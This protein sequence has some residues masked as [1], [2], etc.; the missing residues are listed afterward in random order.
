MMINFFSCSIS[1]ATYSRN[2]ENGGF[3]TIISI[4]SG[5]LIQCNDE[6]RNPFNDCESGFKGFTFTWR[7][8]HRWNVFSGTGKAPPKRRSKGFIMQDG[9]ADLIF[10][11][12][13]E[14]LFPSATF[15]LQAVKFLRHLFRIKQRHIPVVHPIKASEYRIGNKLLHVFQM[16]FSG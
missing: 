15:R 5:Y 16:A 6:S 7:S 9:D 11:Y 13:L 8:I 10:D 2:K 14:A 3:V 12:T 4:L 1:C